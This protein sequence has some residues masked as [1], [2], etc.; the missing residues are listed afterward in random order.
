M[1]YSISHVHFLFCWGLCLGLIFLE[2]AKEILF[3][4]KPYQVLKPFFLKH[5]CAR[6]NIV[7]VSSMGK[8][9]YLFKPLSL[10]LDQLKYFHLY[11]KIFSIK[12]ELM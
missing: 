6:R 8:T 10:T 12:D 2:A 11:L 4:E 1:I 7:G 3:S 5:G 9:R